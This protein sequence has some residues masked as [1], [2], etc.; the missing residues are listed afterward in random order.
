MTE[1]IVCKSDVQFCVG[2]YGKGTAII[3]K[4]QHD[5]KSDEEYKFFGCDYPIDGDMTWRFW[6]ETGTFGGF[7][8]TVS[9]VITEEDEQYYKKIVRAMFNLSDEL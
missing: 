8:Y 6:V 3:G 7:A 2:T 4:L 1:N 5:E 9:A